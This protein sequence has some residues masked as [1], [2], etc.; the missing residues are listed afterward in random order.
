MTVLPNGPDAVEDMPVIESSG[1]NDF[2][3]F[4]DPDPANG[5]SGTVIRAAFLNKLLLL[6][7]TTFTEAQITDT[8]AKPNSLM[9]AIRAL[10]A[11]ELGATST[12]T[13]TNRLA[14]A[15]ILG[16]ENPNDNI[17]LGIIQ[18]LV[19]NESD[20]D[21]LESLA[22]EA[23]NQI[24]SVEHTNSTTKP[25]S[26]EWPSPPDGAKA[27]VSNAT[28]NEFEFWQ[29]RNS[30]WVSLGKMG[31]F[32]ALQSEIDLLNNFKA[33]RVVTADGTLVN[34]ET[35]IVKTDVAARA[36]ALPAGADD[37]DITVY[38]LGTYTGNITG[39]EDTYQLKTSGTG[40]HLMRISGEYFYEAKWMAVTA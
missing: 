22:I 3:W 31:D 28:S 8:V 16:S 38:I 12:Q 37:L 29:R 26:G 13:E 40:V 23:S 11:D 32:A 34:G 21:D 39:G 4:E 24:L 15:S 30:A 36:M 6:L 17:I 25:T 27:I 14:I 1:D 7:R 5:K 33:S 35:V 20:I 2:G 9:L 10:A 18:R 19:V